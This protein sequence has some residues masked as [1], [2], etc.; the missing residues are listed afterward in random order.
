MA[1]PREQQIALATRNEQSTHDVFV[2]NAAASLAIRLA[3]K[4][5]VRHNGASSSTA[6]SSSSS[7]SSSSTSS[8]SSATPIMSLSAKGNGAAQDRMRSVRERYERRKKTSQLKENT[9]SWLTKTLV[10]QSL[11][12]E[13]DRVTLT[14][15]KD[16][17]E[18]SE[19][20]YLPLPE[21]YAI[22]LSALID[23]DEQV[24]PVPPGSSPK[25]ERALRLQEFDRINNALA[26]A[27]P[28]ICNTGIRHAW[29]M[30]LNGYEG[31]RLP[32]NADDLLFRGLFDFMTQKVLGEQMG[33]TLPEGRDPQGEERQQFNM[34]FQSLFLPWVFE[35]MPEH[36]KN[37]IA[38][39]GGSEGAQSFVL[40]RFQEIESLPDTNMMKKIADYCSMAGL[41]TIPC[42]FTPLLAALD[43]PTLK[44]A[45]LSLDAT[46]ANGVEQIAR[47][48]LH[49]LRSPDFFPEALDR[50]N[51]N[52]HAPFAKVYLL[53]RLLDAIH[54][55]KTHQTLLDIGDIHAEDHRAWEHSLGFMARCLGNQA[56]SL[57]ELLSDTETLE[58]TIKAFEHGLGMW[59]NSSFHDFISNYFANWH[60]ATGE[61]GLAV[62]ANLFTKLSELFFRE[63]ARTQNA[64]P[65]IRVTD[66]KLAEWTGRMNEDGVLDITPYQINRILL[67]ALCY[68]Q[69]TWSE[70]FTMNLRILLRFLRNRF[71]EAQ[72]VGALA[73]ARDSYPDTLLDYVE[74]MANGVVPETM[75]PILTPG[76]I[77]PSTS[78][79]VAQL[80]ASSKDT[81]EGV[82]QA[83]IE[84]PNFNPDVANE[85]GVTPF[86]LAAEEGHVPLAAA[87]L[88]RGANCFAMKA[89]SYL[90]LSTALSQEHLSFVQWFLGA[91]DEDKRMEAI[92]AKDKG[93]KTLLHEATR[94]P[95]S[96]ELVLTYVPEAQKAVA[97]L[98]QDRY[99]STVLHYA[100]SKTKTLNIVLGCLPEHVKVDAI[101]AKDHYSKNVL[102]Y[103]ATNLESL[104]LL[105]DCLPEKKFTEALM[106]KDNQ[107]MTVLHE[108]A[109][110]PECLG[111]LLSCLPE[112]ERA[113]AVL[114]A[115]RYNMTVLSKA[116]NNP[117]FLLALL[118]CIPKAKRV[119]LLMTKDRNGITPIEPT[120]SNSKALATLLACLPEESRLPF[121]LGE[122]FDGDTLLR[123]AVL[124]PDSLS[125]LLASLPEDTR[126]AA[127]LTKNR[128]GDDL[129]NYA[130]IYSNSVNVLWSCLTMEERVNALTEKRRDDNTLLHKA[131]MRPEFLKLF[132]SE[133]P[134]QTRA[135]QVMAKNFHGET[136][137]HKAAKNPESLRLLLTCI[138]ENEQ[139]EAV[140]TK[141]NYGRTILH[142]T[143]GDPKC[144]EILLNCLPEEVRADVVMAKDTQGATLL[145]NAASNPKC[146]GL[147]LNCLPQESRVEALVEVNGKNNS[148][149]SKVAGDPQSL[150][151]LMDFI[152]KAQRAALLMTKNRDGYRTPIQRALSNPEALR[153]LITCLPEE[154]RIPFIL[155]KN[156][157][158]EYLDPLT[159][160]EMRNCFHG[161]NLLQYA[162]DNPRSL[163]HLLACL[164]EGTRAEA[165][166][167]KNRD[168]KTLLDYTPRY[169]QAMEVL[170]SYLTM[171]EK[172][173]TVMEKREN[174]N[175]VL[176]ITA[177]EPKFLE[178][179][180]NE[181][182]EQTKTSQVM[183]RNI[184]G[185]TALHWAA[186]YPE[187]LRLLLACIPKGEQTEAVMTKDQYNSTILHYAVSNPKSLSLL[188]ACIPEREQADVMMM[189][190]EC[191]RT[192]LHKAAGYP[193]SL[194]LVLACLPKDKI[195][196]LLMAK[197]KNNKTVLDYAL[198][199]WESQ[200][201][202]QPYAEKAKSAAASSH[203][204]FSHEHSS[205]TSNPEHRALS[206]ETPQKPGS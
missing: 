122:N 48:M 39:A 64:M 63:N 108:A 202:L 183:A 32:L 125:Q 73:L 134:K 192:I 8:S 161:D 152:P 20:W 146:L 120:L 149:L 188:L 55:Y 111:F 117:E 96:L 159:F 6:S 34:Q 43:H 147:L 201:I 131:A 198:V 128:Y 195:P 140:M 144:L 18:I 171:E 25:Q 150:L 156:F 75:P 60:A 160:N 151:S 174:D 76:N 28:R 30:A 102:H 203:S 44:N 123:R 1:D 36:V 86:Y 74:S 72:G 12:P 9:K 24:W 97:L 54:Q 187:S 115:N 167:A 49:W 158:K 91:L 33:I 180:L 135:S 61:A 21:I 197:D 103:A 51:D 89:G 67:H 23:T 101:M 42:N 94:N 172:L 145:Y 87:L 69:D 13:L 65:A 118:D 124:Y 15:T 190:D 53:T 199:K 193:E 107:G 71:N 114:E 29:L 175:T 142:E 93:K 143:E 62:R 81:P 185:E 45:A 66:S 41:E 27:Y 113:N 19:Q 204:F 17:T 5:L 182:P 46:P 56:P 157:A 168:G 3:H 11:H 178:L 139:A 95:Q 164:P 196:E 16:G 169:L 37:A 59:K 35:G 92:L 10:D 170:W 136:V 166:L 116:A 155:E 129:L 194:K 99:Q 110:K 179:F 205:S 40:S 148:V 165:L 2:S 173:Q 31:K 70:T 52:E 186:E 80:L 112:E 121:I 47:E 189:K 133:L 138:P 154:S 106:A 90:P 127:V 50:A 84:H 126:A 141:S 83:L 181:L 7:S 184:E 22:V 82:I 68:T 191:G 119:E 78:F 104:T 177:D 153:S 200:R 79:D 163:S 58:R 4:Y 57:Q 85:D 105:R 162:V 38:A 132:L 26:T 130:V 100:A 137:L 14:H 88:A 206:S 98:S 109:S 77:A 176:H